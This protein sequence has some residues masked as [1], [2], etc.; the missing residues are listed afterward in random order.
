MAI[1]KLAVSTLFAVV[2]A[3]GSATAAAMKLDKAILKL[4]VTGF[5]RPCLLNADLMAPF[6]C[7][8]P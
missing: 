7:S 6:P 4:L 1:S 3:S 5:N 8:A 2:I